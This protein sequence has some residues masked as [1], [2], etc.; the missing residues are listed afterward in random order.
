M[1]NNI[2][3]KIKELK[4]KKDVLVLA[5]YYQSMDIQNI[6]DYCGDSF[7]LAKR[8]KASDK[9]NIIFCGVKFMAESAKVLNPDKNVYIPKP[10][11]G[12]PMADMVTPEDIK[13]LRHRHP[14]AKVVCYINSSAATKE[15]CDVCV[16][17]SNAIKV[18]S[19]LDSKEIIFVPDKNLGAYVAKNMPG[20]TFIL[21]SGWCPV[22]K[23]LTAEDVMTVKAQYPDAPV[24][25][26]PECEQSVLDL[27]D[28]IGSTSEILDYARKCDSHTIIIG[29]E[30]GVVQR[31]EGELPD[32]KIVL[33]HTKLLC[34][35]MKKTT[36]EDVLSTLEDVGNPDTPRLVNMT[37]A[38]MDG[39]RQP[40][41][42]MLELAK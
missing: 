12:C 6:A 40:L 19:K 38:Q 14:K 33:L 32:K 41:E 10:D 18:I 31:L 20:K 42:K 21:H 29:T 1:E 27:A 8:A 34:A 16:T 7:E 28:M 11:A 5:H 26:H 35:D 2:V 24:L 30:N 9:Q 3:D 17:S 23:E 22:H 4:E 39:A 36:L 37:P 15:Q 25:C 13:A